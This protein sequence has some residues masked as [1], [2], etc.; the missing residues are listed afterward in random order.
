MS[1]PREISIIEKPPTSA[2]WRPRQVS[3]ADMAV[4]LRYTHK[5]VHWIQTPAGAHIGGGHVFTCNVTT[6]RVTGGVSVIQRHLQWRSKVNS[7]YGVRIT[8]QSRDLWESQCD[9][10]KKHRPRKLGYFHVTTISHSRFQSQCI[11]EERADSHPANH[12]AAGCILC[13][14]NEPTFLELEGVRSTARESTINN[15]DRHT[16]STAHANHSGQAFASH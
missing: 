2:F 13:R 1:I 7:S 9:R 12:N 8:I 15:K 14:S 4:T 10:K 11:T 5:N 3:P 16:H 6:G